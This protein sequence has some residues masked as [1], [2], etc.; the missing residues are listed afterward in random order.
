M[1]TLIVLVIPAFGIMFPG[2]V[3]GW[4][5]IVP[6]YYLVDTVHQVANFDSGWGDV[7]RSLLI[8]LGF[9]LVIVT[10]GIIALGRRTR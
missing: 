7:W 4:I 9:D 1:P 8:L 5:E 2:A 6:S 10:I 3:S